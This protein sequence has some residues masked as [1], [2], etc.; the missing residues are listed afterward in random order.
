MFFIK[1]KTRECAQLGLFDFPVGNSFIAIQ[2]WWCFVRIS[3]LLLTSL[4]GDLLQCLG[5]L[6]VRPLTM[7]AF[8]LV[9]NCEG[10]CSRALQGQ[11]SG[12]HG[13]FPGKDLYVF[14]DCLAP[15]IRIPSCQG[16]SVDTLNLTLK[17]C[18][19]FS[20]MSSAKTA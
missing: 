18:M 17:P 19:T 11:R 15:S 2:I 10:R 13:P 20:S 7:S 4:F 9:E 14:D 6:A 1:R 3:F 8:T 5:L 12:Q 16:C